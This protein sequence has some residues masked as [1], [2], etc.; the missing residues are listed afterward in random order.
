MPI[1]AIDDRSLPAAPGPVTERAAA[2]LRA[3][4]QR[5]LAA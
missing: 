4:V 3:R 1:T 2:A 5:E